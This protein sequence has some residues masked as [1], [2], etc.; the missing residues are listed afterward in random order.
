MKA[1]H[2]LRR[3]VVLPVVV[4]MALLLV[5]LPTA[6][7]MAQEEQ[8]S[9]S[10]LVL[11]SENSGELV[12]SWE[13]PDPEPTDYRI[14]WA[15]ASE[16]YLG[17]RD[18]NE[19][20]R[21]NAYPDGSVRS[22][23]V[24][25]LLAGAE[26]KVRMRGRYFNDGD[27]SPQWSGPWQEATVTL[28][29]AP[30]PTATPEPTPTPEPVADGAIRGFSL[31]SDAEGELTVSWDT[32]DPAP[33]DYRVSWGPADQEYLGWQAEN[34]TQRGNAYPGGGKLRSL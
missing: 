1:G 14:S 21:G 26:Y 6:R 7:L 17:W 19:D 9:I 34:E 32:A 24:T 23:T 27:T 33:S 8:G 31:V 13:T 11:G 3:R 16:D 30:E 15:L 28:A 12:V 2:L 20:D 29:G 25:G 4:V 5:G 22:H 10:G 18:A